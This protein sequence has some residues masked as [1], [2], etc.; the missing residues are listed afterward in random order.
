MSGPSLVLALLLAA[1]CTGSPVGDPCV[2]ESI[3]PGGFDAREIYLETSSVQCRTRVCMVY[4]LTGDPGNICEDTG[5]APGCLP[6]ATVNSQVFCS[7]RCSI[8]EGGQANTPLCDCGEGFNCVND[9]VTTGGEGVRGGYCVPCIEPG[10]PR[11]LD[12]AV[13]DAC[14]AS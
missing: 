11:N 1:G 3:P 9:I 13:F 6:R 8:S 5:N 10:N 14:P 12:S 4:E 2:P 7:C